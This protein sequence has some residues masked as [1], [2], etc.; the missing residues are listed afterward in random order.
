MI[1]RA[2]QFKEFNL[3]P[4][5]YSEAASCIKLKKN[6]NNTLNIYLMKVRIDKGTIFTCFNWKSKI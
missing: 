4:P 1:T 5:E 2:N 6:N 3:K